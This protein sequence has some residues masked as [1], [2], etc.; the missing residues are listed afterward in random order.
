[1]GTLSTLLNPRERKE[2][3]AGRMKTLVLA[4]VTFDIINCPHYED[5]RLKVLLQLA[6]KD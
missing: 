3:S 2:R 5:Y 4:P 1:M 6:G